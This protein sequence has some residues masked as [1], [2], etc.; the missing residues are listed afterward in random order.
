[1]TGKCCGRNRAEI[2]RVDGFWRH[3]L[4]ENT[5]RC[6]AQRDFSHGCAAISLLRDI[7][8]LPHPPSEEKRCARILQGRTR[9]EIREIRSFSGGVRRGG[10]GSDDRTA[11]Q[12][13]SQARSTESCVRSL[14]PRRQSVAVNWRQRN[15]FAVATKPI[16]ARPGTIGALACQA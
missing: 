5:P 1:M 14:L 13:P 6:P 3:F 16:P 2:T 10:R 7:P 4:I 12:S 9:C 8:L 15:A 11:V